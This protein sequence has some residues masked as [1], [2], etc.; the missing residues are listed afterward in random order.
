MSSRG[1][2]PPSSPTHF[3]ALSSDP[4][5]NPL[6]NR[7]PPGAVERWLL[8]VESCMRRTLHKLAGEALVA[9]AATERSRWILEWPGQLVLNCSQVIGAA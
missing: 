2:C 1:S 6:T 9:Y 7:A 5:T 4:S 8:D 3:S